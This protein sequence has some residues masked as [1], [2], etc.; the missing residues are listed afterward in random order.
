MYQ[1]AACLKESNMSV[2]EV[3]LRFELNVTVRAL[4][5]LSEAANTLEIC[6][7]D[8]VLRP[9]FTLFKFELSRRYGEDFQDLKRKMEQI[10]QTARTLV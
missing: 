6:S 3:P 9:S 10:S 2:F 1:H 8:L 5:E 7:S 4:I